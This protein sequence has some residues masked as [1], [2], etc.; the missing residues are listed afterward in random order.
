MSNKSMLK[1]SNYLHVSKRQHS[2]PC[3]LVFQEYSAFICDAIR[4]V[5]E[6]KTLAISPLGT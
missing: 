3:Y 4:V 1:F 5:F 6:K 2:F